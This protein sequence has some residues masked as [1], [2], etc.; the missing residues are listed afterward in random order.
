MLLLGMLLLAMLRT[1]NESL[2][3]MRIRHCG[4]LAN[5]CRAAR[6]AQIREA[7]EE[8][9]EAQEQKTQAELRTGGSYRC[10]RCRQGRLQLVAIR[11]PQ[12]RP[13]HGPLKVR[14]PQRKH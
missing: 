4:F 6:L 7:I 8:E 10:P 13:A 2:F 3:I 9:A 12:Q 1:T 11:M 5:R 14:P